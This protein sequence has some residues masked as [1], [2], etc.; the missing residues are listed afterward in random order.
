MLLNTEK[1]RRLFEMIQKDL[2]IIPAKLEDCMQPNL[3]HPSIMHKDRDTFERY[4]VEHGLEAAMKYF[5]DI[6]WRYYV[7]TAYKA[8]KTVGGAVLRILKLR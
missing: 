7:N 5:G 1:G 4:Y 3:I 8:I 2:D 6:G